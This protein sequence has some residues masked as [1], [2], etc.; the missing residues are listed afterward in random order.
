MAA[1]RDGRNKERIAPLS[2]QRRGMHHVEFAVAVHVVEPYILDVTFDDGARRRV[3][4]EAE[5]WGPIFEPLRDP[6]FF[7]QAAVDPVLGTVVW[8]NGADV[9]PEFLYYGEDGPPPGYYDPQEVPDDVAEDEEI[10]PALS[11]SR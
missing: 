11:E 5:L 3:D 2:E 1:N 9:S 4:L 8:P 10:V 7:A 6:A